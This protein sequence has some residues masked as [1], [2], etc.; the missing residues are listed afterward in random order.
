MRV[1]LAKREAGIGHG[2]GVVGCL[3]LAG[4]PG[5]EIQGRYF[6]GMY[7][8]APLICSLMMRNGIH[9]NGTGEIEADVRYH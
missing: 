7:L 3:V 9:E 1:A 5:F 8:L 2:R 4:S 6:L